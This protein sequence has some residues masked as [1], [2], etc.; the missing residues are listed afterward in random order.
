MSV[1]R[2]LQLAFAFSASR[3]FGRA[4]I[5]VNGGTSEGPLMPLS[6]WDG[7]PFLIPTDFT[8]GFLVHSI[9]A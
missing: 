2:E 3:Q 5:A 1:P 9:S 6:A 8:W 7:S 4:P